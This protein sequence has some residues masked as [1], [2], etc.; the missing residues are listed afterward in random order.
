ARAL[1]GADRFTRF[2]LHTRA[3]AVS[4]KGAFVSGI[5]PDRIA[6]FNW[7]ISAAVAGLAGILIA[8]IVPLVPAAYT[9]F[10]VPALA[11]A[12]AGRFQSLAVGVAA[13]LV[14][15]M[16]QSEVTY[17]QGRHSWLPKS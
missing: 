16:L 12:I 1:A 8:P 6:A 3:A 7:M 13:G 10:I 15:G 17:L 5:S 4:E 11:A 9:L 2:G 14:I